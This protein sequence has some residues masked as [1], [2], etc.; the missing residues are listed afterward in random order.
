MWRYRGAGFGF[1]ARSRSVPSSRSSLFLLYFFPSKLQSLKTITSSSAI[2]DS[3]FSLSLKLAHRMSSIT[4]KHR[5]PWKQSTRRTV[6]RSRYGSR[7]LRARRNHK[8]GGKACTSDVSAKL[9]SLQSLIPTRSEDGGHRRAEELFQQT[10]DYI[11]LL[12]NQVFVLQRL[13]E[14]Y[15]SGDLE[16]AVSS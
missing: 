3:P 9:E 14:F 4:K 1:D 10:A 8:N 5:I 15:G 16:N 12:K 6:L 7:I 11:V 13:I 2:R